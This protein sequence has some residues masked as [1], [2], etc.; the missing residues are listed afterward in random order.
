MYTL[1]FQ[2]AWALFTQR[3]D[4][5]L[6]LGLFLA[7]FSTAMSLGTEWLKISTI[8]DLFYAILETDNSWQALLQHYW[9][10]VLLAVVQLCVHAIL[11]IGVVAL[12]LAPQLSWRDIFSHIRQHA[13]LV[14]GVTLVVEL[15]TLLGL[16]VLIIPGIIINTLLMLSAPFIVM[17]EQ[18]TVASALHRSYTLIKH[19]MWEAFGIQLLTSCI[20]LA[21]GI[22]W[23]LIV[24]SFPWTIVADFSTELILSLALFY[25]TLVIAAYGETLISTEAPSA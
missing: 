22:A 23:S 3:F 16:V 19:H 8:E 14:V 20:A 2:R 25:S 1:V 5:L 7:V 10:G 13:V 24:S 4:I 9:Q 12:I 11:L 18:H 21:M 17:R 6:P 15:I